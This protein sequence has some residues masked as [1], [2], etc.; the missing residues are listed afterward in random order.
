[1]PE[2][3]RAA[4]R[5]IGVG[6]KVVIRET[7]RRDAFNGSFHRCRH[8]SGIQY[9]DGVIEAMVNARN[10]NIWLVAFKHFINGKLHT[11]YRCARA[12]VHYHILIDMNAVDA[13]RFAN[14]YRMACSRLGPFWR[15]DGDIT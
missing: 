14:G 1:Y 4:F 5:K 7:D 9:V 8:G 12:L 2:D 10:A 11:V 3:V 6:I 13:Q 15:Y